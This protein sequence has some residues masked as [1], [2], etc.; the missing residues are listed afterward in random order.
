M[1]LFER[2]LSL[3]MLAF[4]LYVWCVPI[5][6]AWTLGKAAGKQEMAASEISISI[7][8]GLALT[9]RTADTNEGLMADGRI[10]IELYIG[11]D[12]EHGWPEKTIIRGLRVI[13]VEREPRVADIIEAPENFGAH[14]DVQKTDQCPACQRM[15]KTINRRQP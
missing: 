13:S 6:T 2:D 14:L 5:Y 4:L 8:D 15:L 9:L 7:A 1:K 11:P 10:M 12:I 3:L